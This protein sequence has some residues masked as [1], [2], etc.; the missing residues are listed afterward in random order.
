LYASR[1]EAT[2]MQ[3]KVS[4]PTN[5]KNP[6]IKA[7]FSIQLLSLEKMIV[8]TALLVKVQCVPAV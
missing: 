1:K 6:P 3:L 7:G 8:S 4:Y 2:K 5:E